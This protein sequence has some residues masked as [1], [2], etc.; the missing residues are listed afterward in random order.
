MV[1][2][3]HNI[4]DNGNDMK[5]S[6]TCTVEYIMNIPNVT[7]LL[8]IIIIERNTEFQWK[9]NPVIGNIIMIK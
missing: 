4:R 1:V 3:I 7:V 2:S 5:I 9:L 6:L 8:S